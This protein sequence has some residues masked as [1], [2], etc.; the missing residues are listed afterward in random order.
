MVS[1]LDYKGMLIKGW[2][3]ICFTTDEKKNGWNEIKE[4]R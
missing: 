3:V 2:L 1:N 4:M